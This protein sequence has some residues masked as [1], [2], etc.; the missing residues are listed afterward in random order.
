MCAAG[1][2]D[3]PLDDQGLRSLSDTQHGLPRLHRVL[4][5]QVYLRVP[6]PSLANSQRQSSCRCDTSVQ[7]IYKGSYSEY[8]AYQLTLSCTCLVCP[9]TYA[10]QRANSCLCNVHQLK[11]H[12]SSCLLTMQVGL[13]NYDPQKDKRFSG[14]VKLPYMPRPGMKVC[15]QQ[16]ASHDCSGI[17]QCQVCEHDCC[18]HSL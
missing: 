11:R 17:L 12:S 13:K 18:S 9:S 1:L 14:T 5:F 7:L 3:T 4:L 10:T 6:R 8:Q 15:H 16:S 2:D